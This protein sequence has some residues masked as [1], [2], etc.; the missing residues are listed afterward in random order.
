MSFR[1]WGNRAAAFPLTIF[2]KC[3][4]A[5]LRIQVFGK[6]R[7][8]RE[9]ST[10]AVGCVFLMWHDSILLSLLLRWVPTFQ[11]ICVLISYSK[12][13]DIA[14]EIGKQFSGINVIRVKHT[15][16]AGA[17]V[18]GCRLLSSRQSLFIPPDG[19]RGPRHQVKLGAL[20]A[21]QQCGSPI[22]PIVYAASRQ[23]TLSSWDKFRIP[24]PFSKVLFS[25]LEPIFCP[26]EGDLEQFRV[27]IEQKMTEEE[28][29]L[30]VLLSVKV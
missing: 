28:R 21:C 12:D 23:R 17:L 30:T 29:R 24:L 26:H 13:G 6:D 25:F 1:Q 22:I 20:Y 8:I 9:L 16:R 10:S 11:P 19:P 3:Y 15:S 7:T 14:A 4:I 18:E 27:E 5:T 2:L